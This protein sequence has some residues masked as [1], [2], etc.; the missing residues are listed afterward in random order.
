[1]FMYCMCWLKSKSTNIKFILD[2]SSPNIN[3][4]T[5]N[6]TNTYTRHTHTQ[7]ST[8]TSIQS[9]LFITSLFATTQVVQNL[10]TT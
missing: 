4:F 3:D 6:A 9:T 8:N 7:N 10:H 5:E 2:V 1:M